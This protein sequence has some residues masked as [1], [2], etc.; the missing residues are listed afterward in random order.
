MVE[1]LSVYGQEMVEY[2]VYHMMIEYD[3][4]SSSLDQAVIWMMWKT[5]TRKHLTWWGFSPRS[6]AN[7]PLAAVGSPQKRVVLPDATGYEN[8]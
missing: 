6:V 4:T 1:K 8:S 3:I 5:Q 2:R 7:K